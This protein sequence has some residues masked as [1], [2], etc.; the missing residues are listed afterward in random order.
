MCKKLIYLISFVLV[1]SLAGVP[2]F[3]DKYSSQYNVARVLGSQATEL[4]VVIPHPQAMARAGKENIVL[5]ENGRIVTQIVP[6]ERE[7][8]FGEAA[9]L[10][11]LSLKQRGFAEKSDSAATKVFITANSM[12]T[13]KTSTP[14]PEVLALTPAEK[15]ALGKSD[16]AYV[17]RMKPG[18]ESVIWIVGASP[19]GA[20]YG[21][22]TLVQL[23]ETHRPN[24]AT[25]G[26]IEVQDYPDIPYRMCADWELDVDVGTNCY[27]WGDGLD[28]FIA[29][30][31]R[32]I[33]MCSRYKVNMVRFLGGRI[34]PGPDY[35][36][37]RYAMIKRFA[38]EL[39]RYARRKG[40]A[41]Q[42]D[43]VSWGR[44]YCSIGTP[45]DTAL[46]ASEPWILNREHYPDGKIYKCIGR[47]APGT[48]G[49]CLSNDE[50]TQAIV[51]RHRRFVEDNE[52]GSIYL[53]HIDVTSYDLYPGAL[54]PAWKGRCERCRQKYPDDE[55][56]SPTGFAGAVANLYN[57]ITAELKSVKNSTSGY[58]A[59]RDLRIVFTSPCYGDQPGYGWA[60]KSDADWDKVLKYFQEIGRQVKDKENVHLTFREE[61]K[62]VD[63][64]GLKTEEMAR[65]LSEVRWPHGVFMFPIQGGG[66]W[67]DNHMLVSS[68][69]LTEIYRGASVIYNFNGHVH[70]EVQ[71]LA[72]VN[73]AWNHHAPGCVDPM[74]F[75]G[76]AL[77]AEASQYASGLKH[78]DYIYGRFLSAACAKLYGEKAAPYMAQMFR[79]EK[80]KGPIL[81]VMT[82]LVT[83][84]MR[85]KS[86]Y[87]WAAQAERNR[88][89]K[90]L[91]D[92][93]LAV[94]D[95]EA[96]EDLDWLSKCLEVGARICDFYHLVYRRKLPGAEINAKANELLA[97]LDENFQF[98]KTEPDGGDPAIWKS[99]VTRAQRR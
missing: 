79:L 30:S 99:L 76:R 56:F 73:Y 11:K 36:K 12:T 96:K 14:Q 35:M 69:V 46:M 53:H 89:A 16:Q 66:F 43:S 9:D 45:M 37:Q 10:I 64:K 80:E 62:R 13:E 71:V 3:A 63:N 39:N 72:N 28:A 1:L 34:A 58:D 4:P 93:A 31:K 7:G 54:V 17:I 40:V 77:Q 92:K 90:V 82:A 25:V 84:H 95:A 38:L 22:T 57:T 61:F 97:W 27:D 33:D 70:S 8:F 50:L 86:P 87:D 67:V 41:L 32:K 74:P 81:S 2:A 55:P 44:D 52:P 60:H 59:A 24:R 19:L 68:P 91:V 20:Y 98:Q 51:D 18:E 75:E 23:I 94:C 5:G 21:A 42:Y 47:Y 85:N 88:R 49:S 26:N 65:Y 48:A 29:R 15:A 78:S 6:A 83:H